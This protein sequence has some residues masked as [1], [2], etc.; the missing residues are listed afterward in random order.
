MKAECLIWNE[1]NNSLEK[2]YISAYAKTTIFLDAKPSR[3]IYRGK[4]KMYL[5]ISDSNELKSQILRSV[6]RLRRES[7][8]RYAIYNSTWILISEAIY[9]SVIMLCFLPIQVN[10][11]LKFKLFL[12]RHLKSST[13]LITKKRKCQF[14]APPEYPFHV[15]FLSTNI[16]KDPRGYPVLIMLNPRIH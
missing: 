11:T 5:Q 1:Q 8:V 14:V 3:V 9:N 6:R 13:E 10:S 2:V 16:L 7:T 4:I 15:M 12:L